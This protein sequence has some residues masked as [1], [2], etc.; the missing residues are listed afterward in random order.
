M[1]FP[2]VGGAF[3]GGGGRGEIIH[4]ASCNV[5]SRTHGH[6]GLG[7]IFPVF[8]VPCR[9]HSQRL[10]TSAGNS[11]SIS[12]VSSYLSWRLSTCTRTWYLSRLALREMRRSSNVGTD[13]NGSDDSSAFRSENEESQGSEEGILSGISGTISSFFGGESQS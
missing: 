7:V 10:H 3:A 1:S 9:G 5:P 6:M 13:K 11:F 4:A 8:V 2:Q 12:L